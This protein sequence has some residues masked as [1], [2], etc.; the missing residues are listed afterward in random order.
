MSSEFIEYVIELLEPSGGI[1]KSRMFGGYAIRKF[2]LAIALVFQDEIYFKVNESNV[3]DYKALN[4]RP[5]TYEK[6]GKIITM[7]NWL[8]PVEVLED[9]ERL[10]EFVEK[11]YQVALK[12]KGL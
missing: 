12:A 10:K 1:S 6:K 5:F 7:S 2:G 3:E 9:E 8:L 11:S 4:S